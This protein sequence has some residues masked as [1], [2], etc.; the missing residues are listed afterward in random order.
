M[1]ELEGVF[2][3]GGPRLIA[4]ACF[5]GGNPTRFTPLKS[6]DPGVTPGHKSSHGQ[7]SK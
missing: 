2:C 3:S 5:A 6:N 4:L 7:L 1:G